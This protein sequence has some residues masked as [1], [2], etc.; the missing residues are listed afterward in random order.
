M[1]RLTVTLPQ[2]MKRFVEEQAAARG[3]STTDEYLRDLI[4]EAQGRLE[5]EE[6]EAAL[7]AGLASPVSDMT[8]ADWTALRQRILDRNPDLADE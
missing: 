7:A 8:Q 3:F 5:H 6:L 2:P 1:T 4:H